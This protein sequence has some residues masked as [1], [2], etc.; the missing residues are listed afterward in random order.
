MYTKNEKIDGR[1]HVSV[2]RTSS[3]I[4]ALAML[5]VIV[6]LA[7]EREIVKV[8]NSSVKN[9]VVL[10]DIDIRGKGAQLMCFKTQSDCLVPKPGE[11]L[12]ERLRGD[13]GAYMDCQNADLYD[14]P[15]NSKAESK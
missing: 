15:A 13:N 6:L 3:I 9:N 8:K 1:G 7:S 11:Y 2:R 4:T 14:Q 12:M 10:V 5:P